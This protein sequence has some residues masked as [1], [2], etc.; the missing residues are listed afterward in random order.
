[1]K[2]DMPSTTIDFIKSVPDL[3]RQK[4]ILEQISQTNNA[5]LLPYLF[6]VKGEPFSL[7]DR[8]QFDVLFEKTLYPDLIIM[9]GRQLGKC[10]KCT[11]KDD[12]LALR[13][14][15]GRRLDTT[16][17]NPA[18]SHVASEKDSVS[19]TGKVTCYISSGIKQ[20]LEI[21]TAFGRTLQV[22]EDH[23][24]RT[25]DGYEKAGDLSVGSR[26]MTL[27]KCYDFGMRHESEYRIALTA[28]LIGD[29]CCGLGNNSMEIT[30]VGAVVEHVK[31]LC[32]DEELRIR[33]YSTN[34]N[35][36]HL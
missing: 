25:F 18:I 11:K 10:E 9:S 15:L 34:P 22:S 19:H 4:E 16:F 23:G 29:G 32:T 2:S 7:K 8:P 1:M 35:V 6:R 3:V 28:Y 13:D 12:F 14:S 24:I 27:R 5:D 30:G 17:H 26:V 36:F 21:K 31:R 20:I 33:P